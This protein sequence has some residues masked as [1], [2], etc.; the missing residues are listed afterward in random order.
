M[1]LLIVR[2]KMLEK[3]IPV[4]GHEDEK[5]IV[6]TRRHWV[7][8]LGTII[9]TIILA[10]IPVIFI[11]LIVFLADYEF[12][13]DVINKTIMIL[14]LYYLT[15]A[16]FIYSSWVTYY[17]NIFVVTEQNVIDVYQHGFFARDIT[18]ISLLRI[19]DVSGKIRGFLPTLFGYGNVLAESAGEH[20]R[21]YVI[22][23]IPNPVGVAD[24]IL[25]LHNSYIEKEQRDEE[26]M[27]AEGDL[28]PRN[29][30]NQS[31]VNSNPQVSGDEVC[32]PDWKLEPEKPLP[33]NEENLPTDQSLPPKEIDS[34][35]LDKGGEIKI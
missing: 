3:T 31:S 1:V 9:I 12:S 29:Q 25:E 11:L 27:T 13:K 18:E 7:T 23:G 28:R 35:D 34:D 2:G 14:I 32:V 33:Q 17:Y 20:S 26:I 22:F 21:T 16:T 30:N 5:V 8:F 15:M 10:I 4:P 19:Q 24:K 6:F